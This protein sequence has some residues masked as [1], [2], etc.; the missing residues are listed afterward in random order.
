MLQRPVAYRLDTRSTQFVARETW[1]RQPQLGNGLEQ[2]EN[3]LGG[4]GI[5][6]HPPPVEETEI[7][8]LGRR[9]VLGEAVAYPGPLGTVVE[10]GWKL[11]RGAENLTQHCLGNP[12]LGSLIPG[13]L[14]A[15]SSQAS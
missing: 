10:D 13:D 11:P 2:F 5:R 6:W 9:S 1:S 12:T 7:S 4:G 3:S 8:C 14:W 15:G